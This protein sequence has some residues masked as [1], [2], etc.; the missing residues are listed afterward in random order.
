MDGLPSCGTPQ[1][2]NPD[3][4]KIQRPFPFRNL[5]SRIPIAR[6]RE[7]EAGARESISVINYAT[8]YSHTITHAMGELHNI[9]HASLADNRAIAP[10]AHLPI[11]DKVQ[12]DVEAQID[13]MYSALVRLGLVNETILAHTPYHGDDH[14]LAQG[15]GHVQPLA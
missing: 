1:E 10:P 15:G 7:L 6:L 12:K 4:P 5:H 3:L 11:V 8:T 14:T 13:T 9:L 2:E